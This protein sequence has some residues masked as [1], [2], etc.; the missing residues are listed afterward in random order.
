MPPD[1]FEVIFP[2]WTV[3]G[4]IVCKPCSIINDNDLEGGHSFTIHI[5]A[6]APS[7]MGITIDVPYTNVEITDDEGEWCSQ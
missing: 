1:E 6:V 5:Q 7:L 4:T 3:N 2:P